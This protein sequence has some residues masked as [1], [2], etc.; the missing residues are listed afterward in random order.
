MKKTCSAYRDDL[1]GYRL[2]EGTPLERERMKAHL[3]GCADCRA[4]LAAYEMLVRDA[5]EEPPALAIE[6]KDRIWK[7]SRANSQEPNQVFW[8]QFKDSFSRGGNQP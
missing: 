2:G 6:D 8:T 1:P 3:E 4:H 5:R 7:K